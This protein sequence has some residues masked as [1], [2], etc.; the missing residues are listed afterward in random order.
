MITLSVVGSV[1][2]R[3]RIFLLHLFSEVESLASRIE[4]PRVVVGAFH[5]GMQPQ[6]LSW[7]LTGVGR[8]WVWQGAESLSLHIAPLFPLG[9]VSQGIDVHWVLH[10]LNYL[11]CGATKCLYYRC[12]A[13]AE[14]YIL[15]NKIP[16][17]LFKYPLY[18]EFCDE[19]DVTLAGQLLS[20]PFLKYFGESL[21]DLQ[22]RR[23]ETQAQRSSILIVMPETNGGEPN[24][25]KKNSNVPG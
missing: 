3:R 4:E 5:T 10:P 13:N 15:L 16:G 18:L 19:V 22:P 21:V 17:S 23:V 7:Q 24:Y 6:C 12:N 1:C 11:K 2:N 20:D 8:T 14:A 25:P 9:I